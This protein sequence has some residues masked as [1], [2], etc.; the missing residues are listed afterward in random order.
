MALIRTL[1]YVL[2]P[3]WSVETTMRRLVVMGVLL[4]AG[5]T[6][7]AEKL[8][9]IDFQTAVTDTAEGKSAQSKIDTMYSSR[10]S[11]LERMQGELEKAMADYQKRAMILT[12]D[13]K[14]KAEQELALQQ[15][16]FEQTYMQ[17]QNEMQQ[18]YMGLLGDLDQKMRK[19]AQTV[20]RDQ[21]CSVVI[22]KA[23]VVYAGAEMADVTAPL[24]S[25]YNAQH[26]PK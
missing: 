1:G 15:R 23:V 9:M 4:A 2:G 16:T 7:R 11:E 24:V 10:R 21:G 6:A 22:D 3:R 14:A 5:T 17:Y 13:A 25:K 20:G 8:C 12:G 18:T 26:P 19:I